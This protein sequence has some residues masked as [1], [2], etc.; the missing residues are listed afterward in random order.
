MRL[1]GGSTQYEGRLEIR[2]NNGTWGTVSGSNWSSLCASVACRML[3]FSSSALSPDLTQQFGVGTGPVHI[4][5][6]RCVG[7][8]ISLL[9]CGHKGW[10]ST[11]DHRGD[12]G[13]HC[14]PGRC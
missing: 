6:Y 9:D 3:G 13:L 10:G 8:E 4:V 5:V 7:D 14:L 11:N 2:R 12:I 1:V